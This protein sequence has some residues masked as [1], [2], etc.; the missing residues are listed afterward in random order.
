MTN[1]GCDFY[2]FLETRMRPS[3]NRYMKITPIFFDRDDFTEQSG[4]AL[5]DI[6]TFI[7][8]LIP[9]TTIYLIPDTASFGL[10]FAADRNLERFVTLQHIDR[11]SHA[12]RS[13]QAKLVRDAGLRAGIVTRTERTTRVRPPKRRLATLIIR[14]IRKAGQTSLIGLR[15]Q[16]GIVQSNWQ[17]HATCG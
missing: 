11:N 4:C 9:L 10:Y 6:L 12:T 13:A 5:L 14:R 1:G 8:A 2:D 16:I 17:I 7:C 15:R 3:G